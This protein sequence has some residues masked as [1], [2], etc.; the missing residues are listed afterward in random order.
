MKSANRPPLRSALYLALSFAVTALIGGILLW[1]PWMHGEKLS[2]LD[3][4]FTST[5]AVCVTGLTVVNTATTFTLPGK[6]VI[7]ALIQLGGLGIMTFSTLFFIL[8]GRSVPVIESLSLK[9]SFAPYHGVHLGSLI[10]TIVIYTLGTELVLTLLLIPAFWSSN[11]GEGLFH[12]L[13]HAVSAFCNAGFSDLPAGLTSYSRNL[14][15]PTV[16]ALAILAGNTGFPI[17]FEAVQRLR[18]RGIR[19]WSLHTRLTLTT[20]LILILMGGLLFL[21]FEK[22]RAFTGLS[23]PEKILNAFFLSVSARTAGFNLIDLSRFG[24]VSLY[25]LIFLM[26]VGACPGSTGGGVKTT[27][28]GVLV[29][30]VWSRLRGY[31]RAT[32]FRRTIPQDIVFKALTLVSLYAFTIFL[33]QFLLI[34]SAPGHTFASSGTEFLARLFE[35]VSALGTV[36]LSTGI[37]PQ[38]SPW[39]KV[40]LIFTMYAGRVGV[41][42]LAVLLTGLSS[43]PKEFYYPKEEV[44]LG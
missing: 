22:N 18:S 16:I 13:F 32:V 9:E 35:T 21:I 24:E 25:V 41:L 11:P 7:L 20:H 6:L 40:V 34:L 5:S 43:R 44:L 23:L 14:Y 26:F 2:F 12:A 17:V 1:L 38:L 15:L 30:S 29:A 4:L 19:K 28:F 33:A 27:T 10:L 8:M 31:S 42:S 3:A 37:T 36:G 39:S